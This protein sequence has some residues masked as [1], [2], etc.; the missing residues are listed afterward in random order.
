MDLHDLGWDDGFAAGLEP[1]DNC[2]PAR[3]SAQHRG[4]YDVL[5]RGGE[6]RAHVSGRLRHEASSGA[7]LPAVGDWV[8]LCE[9]TIHA[10]LPR[11]SAFVRKVAFHATEAQVLAANIDTVFVVTGL[12][13]DFSPRRLE[14]YLTLAWES[15]ASPAVVLTK[16]DLCD[17]PPARLLE[18]EQVAVGVPAHVVSNLTGEGLTS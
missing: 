15:G 5:T 3:V 18:V 2:I 13:E 9:T 7:E 4:E 14:R 10:V 16:S 17:D 12:D 8:A 6:L 1:H 11:R